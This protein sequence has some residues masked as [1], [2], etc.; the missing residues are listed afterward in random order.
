MMPDNY[1]L[2]DSAVQAANELQQLYINVFASPEGRKVL[3]H[4]LSEGHFFTT[5]DPD[6]PAQIAE[7]NF[8]KLL[9]YR[10]GIFEL[11]YPQLGLEVR[12]D[13]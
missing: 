8:A 9:A 12:K 2:D 6:N 13:G 3:G 10:A 5:L 7:H 4:I 11:L 1:N